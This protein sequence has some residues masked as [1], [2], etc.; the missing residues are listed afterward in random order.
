MEE[1]LEVPKE[2]LVGLQVWLWPSINLLVSK[3][4][5]FNFLSS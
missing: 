2:S 5:T 3:F 4:L 1:K